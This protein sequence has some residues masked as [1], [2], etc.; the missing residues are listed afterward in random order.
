MKKVVIFGGGT[1]M[2]QIL[3]GLKLF[4]LD[5]TAIVSVLDNGRST[6]ILREIY[7]IPAVGDISKVLLT[8][9]NL[10]DDIE[11]LLSYRIKGSNE[12]NEFNHSIKNL[13]L[14]ALIDLHGSFDAA[15][16]I[17]CKLFDISGRVL[18]LTEE[19]VNL[20][21]KMHDG[22]V[23]V[24]E[25]EITEA[26]KKIES[27]WYDKQFE[28]NPKIFKALENA[29]LII[30]APG[31]LYTSIIPH[32][33]VPEITEAIKKSKAKKL[34]V[35]NLI[36]QPGET[37]DFSVSAH[38]K[39][40]NKYLGENKIDA[41]VANKTNISKSLAKK[42]QTR[43]QKQPVLFDKKELDEMKITVLSDKTYAIEDGVIRHD[44]LKTAYMIF[45]YLMDGK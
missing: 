43:E 25:E 3:K 31:S 39:M 11:E 21:A 34:Y 35:C 20:V 44:S 45:S 18:P 22:E 17:F 29:N 38:I 7:D 42:Y 8:V 19:N 14:T 9:G 32:L 36:T 23:I 10:D 28:P 1:G 40:L 16:P 27:I 6:G 30:F 5:I 37:L 2:S 4:P 15:I 24:G 33:M 13:I 12:N 41:V 26:K